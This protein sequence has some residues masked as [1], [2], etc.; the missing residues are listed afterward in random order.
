ML[1]LPGPPLPLAQAHGGTVGEA[2]KNQ[3]RRG[4]GPHVFFLSRGRHGWELPL[5]TATA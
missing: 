5:G 3:K 2:K 4:A 1:T